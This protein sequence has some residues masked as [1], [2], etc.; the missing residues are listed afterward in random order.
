MIKIEV[1]LGLWDESI[2]IIR[3]SF[4]ALNAQNL[5]RVPQKYVWPEYKLHHKIF[6]SMYRR[7]NIKYGQFK[8]ISM[9]KNRPCPVN[10]NYFVHLTCFRV[11]V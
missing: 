3:I 8:K 2:M 7:C 1:V 11:A 10:K 9:Q 4:E 6:K 5:F